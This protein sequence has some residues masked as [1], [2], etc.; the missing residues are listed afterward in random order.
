M[1]TAWAL[2]PPGGR[3]RE[4]GQTGWHG[5]GSRFTVGAD[6]VVNYNDFNSYLHWQVA[7]PG[8]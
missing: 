4:E 8:F 7:R 5:S 3:E 2:E 1:V 6:V